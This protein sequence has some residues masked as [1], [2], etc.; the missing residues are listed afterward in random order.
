VLEEAMRK[1]LMPFPVE[2]QLNEAEN[3]KDHIFN[4]VEV[5]L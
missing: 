1:A 2:E 4:F 5:Q 3:E